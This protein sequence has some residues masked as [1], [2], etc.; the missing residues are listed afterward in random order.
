MT[1]VFNAVFIAAAALLLPW[2]GCAGKGVDY[3]VIAEP[4]DKSCS[5]CHDVDY[6]DELFEAIETLDNSLFTAE[7]FPD[8]NFPDGLLNKTVEGMISAAD[9]PRDAQMDPAWPVRK[10][11]I[12]H[13]MNELHAL[14]DEDIPA[15]F[16]SQDRFDGFVT[17]V[18]GDHLE[19]CELGDKL[20][21]G[22][23]GDPEGMQPLWAK[24]LFELLDL[25]FE[26][27]S[28][29]DRQKIRDYVD[30]LLPGGLKGCVA[31]EESAS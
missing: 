2:S 12:M 1:A 24:K 22:F 3:S 25:E 29:K 28:D 26:E 27:L 9:P 4:V 23:S 30:E 6:R 19:G 8:S 7:N 21:L 16:T 17:L 13:E 14:L 5:Q 10:A 15:D 20:D 31:G 11:W 18:E